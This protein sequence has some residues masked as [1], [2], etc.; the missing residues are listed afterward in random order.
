MLYVHCIYLNKTVRQKL[1]KKRQ[2]HQNKT[3]QKQE[4]STYEA[5]VFKVKR[6]NNGRKKWG[7]SNF[8]EG[9][10]IEPFDP[11]HDVFT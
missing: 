4:K 6:N 10:R 5:K 7:G 3:K 2:P 11:A 9:V 1:K 8:L